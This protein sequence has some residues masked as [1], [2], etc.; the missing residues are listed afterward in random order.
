[1]FS[2]MICAFYILYKSALPISEL[3]RNPPLLPSIICQENFFLKRSDN[4]YLRCLNLFDPMDCGSP[5]SSVYGFFR[6]EYC[7]GLP[8]PP[9]GDLPNLGIEPASLTSPALAGEFFFF[10]FFNHQHHLGSSLLGFCFFSV[11][12]LI[13]GFTFP[14]EFQYQLDSRKEEKF[15]GIFL[16]IALIL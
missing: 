3:Q 9:P 13:W 5:H 12:A 2:F 6:Q 10:F 7:S 11:C 8:C 16:G 4:K 1:M 15:P 14:Y